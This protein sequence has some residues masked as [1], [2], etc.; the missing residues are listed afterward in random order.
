MAS[1]L[2]CSLRTLPP[3][4]MEKKKKKGNKKENPTQVIATASAKPYIPPAPDNN[5]AGREGKASEKLFKRQPG[6]DNALAAYGQLPKWEILCMVVE[7]HF[8]DGG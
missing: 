4:F 7:P 8:K 5:E 2:S 1:P 3:K 6:T